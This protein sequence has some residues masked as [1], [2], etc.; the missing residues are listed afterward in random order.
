MKIC[1]KIDPYCQQ[2]KCSPVILVSDNIK[3]MPIFAEILWR[4]ASNDSGAVYNV[5]FQCFRRQAIVFRTFT[6]KANIII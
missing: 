5:Y 2:Q 6:D 3:F 1:V 4:G